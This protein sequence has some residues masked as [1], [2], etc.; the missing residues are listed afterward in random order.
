MKKLL[1]LFICF[2]LAISLAGCGLFAE[3][4]E[5]IPEPE[6][7]PEPEP[8]YFLNPL[9]GVYDRETE[10]GGR[11][12][13]IS[14]NNNEYG[15]PQSGVS[16]ADIIVEIETE[17]GIT[18][19]MC[20]FTEPEK[21]AGG[22]GSIRSLR[23]QFIEAI[24]Q[25]DPV[26]VHIGTS[27]Y[28]DEFLWARG[29]KTMNG[30]NSE[31]FIYIDQE[32]REHY[33]SEH[34]KFTDAEHLKAGM[35]DD[36]F[37]LSPEWNPT[38]KTAFNFA[39]ADSPAMLS[40]GSATKIYYEFSAHYDGDF[41]YDEATGTYKKYQHGKP[42]IDA[43]NN[44]TQLAFENV[45]LLF[46]PIY[47]L[48]GELIDIDYGEGGTGYYFNGGKYEK[49]S[50]EKGEYT[51]DFVFKNSGGSVMQINPGRTHLGIIRDYFDDILTINGV[52]PA[53]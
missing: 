42:H 23:H 40:G 47:G 2:M 5:P 41:R 8:V 20:L 31:S 52:T 17:G 24:Y 46:A 35:E 28:T 36:T 1:C 33:D 22:I 15:L 10:Y 32:R 43:G 38:S 19:L 34:T 9:T 37:G 51:D 39:P 26:I 48:Y 4:P 27:N 30:Y 21:A 49:I 7:E 44:N 3:E 45:I 14:V 50:W 53:A 29:I 16:M 12:F 13:A 25:W 11:P 6:P 18:R